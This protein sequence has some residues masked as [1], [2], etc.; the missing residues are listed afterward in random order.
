MPSRRYQRYRRFCQPFPLVD[1]LEIHRL[2]IL[3]ADL[4]VD[5]F[6][7]Y[8]RRAKHDSRPLAP[9]FRITWLCLRSSPLC[10]QTAVIQTAMSTVAKTLVT[11][12]KEAAIVKVRRR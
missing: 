12:P 4:T 3:T 6:S 11:F 1:S 8:W 7:I 9:L 5:K 10:G 2:L